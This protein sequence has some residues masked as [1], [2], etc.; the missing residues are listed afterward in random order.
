M[1]ASAEAD[2]EKNQSGQDDS[3]DEPQT[4]GILVHFPLSS[5]NEVEI[6]SGAAQTAGVHHKDKDKEGSWRTPKA[7]TLVDLVEGYL[8][9]QVSVETDRG[10][11]ISQ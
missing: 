4:S 9:G 11:I 1:D 10:T 8:G 6:E 3:G 7:Q 2:L 5:P